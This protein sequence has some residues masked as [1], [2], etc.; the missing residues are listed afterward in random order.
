MSQPP[1]R[2]VFELRR[3]P[4]KTDEALLQELRR[5]AALIPGQALTVGVFKKHGRVERKIYTKRFGGWFEALNAAGLSERSSDVIPTRGAH[6]SRNM[7]NED[8]IRQ[9]RELAAKL[10]V[11]KLTITHVAEHL[12][13]DAATLRARWGTARSAF[14]AAGLEL[15]RYGRRYTPEECYSNL[16]TVWTHYGRPPKYSEMALPPSQ[17][18]GK[19]YMNRFGTWNKALAAFVER[20]NAEPAP[21]SS[22]P[23][24]QWPTAP[25]QP[26]EQHSGRTLEDARDIPLGLRFRVLHSDRFKCVLCG[27]HPARNAECRLH[28]DHILPWSKGGKTRDDNLRSLCAE[29]NIGRGDRFKD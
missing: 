8:I 14:E 23:E 26:A 7:S 6:P 9:L 11:P 2:P 16:L 10:N 22:S 19:A 18:G 15:S 1:E 3:L 21:S 13:F 20:A 4:E 29:C 5:V 24:P 28:V 17:V 27:D 12:P 25:E